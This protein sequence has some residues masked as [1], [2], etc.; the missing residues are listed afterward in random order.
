MSQRYDYLVRTRHATLPELTQVKKSESYPQRES[1]LFALRELTG[2]DAGTTA[3]DW[4]R[5]L[6]RVL[7]AKVKE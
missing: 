1:V 7:T 4:Q 6:H 3:R 2:K 5:E